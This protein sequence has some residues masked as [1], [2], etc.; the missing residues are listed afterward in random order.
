MYAFGDFY[1]FHLGYVLRS[2][3]ATLLYVDNVKTVS[4]ES[5]MFTY[6]R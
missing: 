6:G 1:M 3:C 2:L 4:L 5:I